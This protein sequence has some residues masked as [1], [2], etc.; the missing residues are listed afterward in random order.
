MAKFPAAAARVYW[1]RSRYG[2]EAAALSLPLDKKTLRTA[3]LCIGGAAILL[4]PASLAALGLGAWLGYR[5]RD[6][7]QTI[8]G[9]WG[10]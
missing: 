8:L 5:Q 3:A 6:W 1:V 4:H 2:R 10:G 9:M 7:I